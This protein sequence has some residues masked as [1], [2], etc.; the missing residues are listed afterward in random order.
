[1]VIIKYVFTKDTQEVTTTPIVYEYNTCSLY[2]IEQNINKRYFF[3]FLNNLFV[4]VFIYLYSIILI[5]S[6]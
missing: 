6:I 4:E 1:M 2:I 3:T 5:D